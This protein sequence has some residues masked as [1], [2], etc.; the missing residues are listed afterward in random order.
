MDDLL[1]NALDEA[2]SLCEVKVAQLAGALSVR[3]VRL[4][5]ATLSTLTLGCTSD[6]NPTSG[7][8]KKT[9]G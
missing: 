5:D 8:Q 9:L 3:R 6:G 2:L 7:T 4:E 1:D